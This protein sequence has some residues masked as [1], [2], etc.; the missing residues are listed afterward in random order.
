MKKKRKFATTLLATAL[1]SYGFTLDSTEEVT[2]EE[3]EQPAE[4]AVEK[5]STSPS[6]GQHLVAEEEIQVEIFEEEPIVEEVESTPTVPTETEP[7]PPE[8]PPQAI[9]LTQTQG[10][11]AEPVA[12]V[13]QAESTQATREPA[14]N[15]PE[16]D[17]MNGID[18]G[19]SQTIQPDVTKPNY[20]EEQLTDPTHAPDGTPVEVIVPE[21]CY[22]EEPTSTK[23]VPIERTVV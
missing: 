20:T 8:T 1:L 12:T 4:V 23:M 6:E 13:T 22:P 7:L 2:T 18:Y 17:T 19:T 3:P 14:I 21:V 9:T 10:N 16:P 15:I 11:T 5:T